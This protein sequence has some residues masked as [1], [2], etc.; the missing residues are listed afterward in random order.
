MMTDLTNWHLSIKPKADSTLLNMKKAELVEY[1][2]VLEH[3]Y[4][5]AVWFNENQ[6][7]NIERLLNTSAVVRCKDCIHQSTTNGFYA[8]HKFMGENVSII[9]N[10]NNYCSCGRRKENV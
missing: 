3:N 7:K 1:I 2:R 5:A 4:N 9:T 10:P 8:C 6:A